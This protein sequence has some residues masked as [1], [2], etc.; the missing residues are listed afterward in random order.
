[1]WERHEISDSFIAQ[2]TQP[3]SYSIR[4]F[5][6][7]SCSWRYSDI[8]DNFFFQHNFATDLETENLIKY[9]FWNHK[10][11]VHENLIFTEVR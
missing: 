10:K 6:N 11:I 4:I 1:M 8:D 3:C 2:E 9:S 5:R 7:F